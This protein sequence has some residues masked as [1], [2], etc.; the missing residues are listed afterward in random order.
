MAAR[1]PLPK[2][3]KLPETVLFHRDHP[4]DPII[5]LQIPNEDASD[6][7]TYILRTDRA[8]DMEWMDKLVRAGDLR[9]KLTMEMHVAHDVKSGF[10]T[11]IDD[12]DAPSF[13]ARNLQTA[14]AQASTSFA[15]KIQQRVQRRN[16]PT[17]MLRRQL[18]GKR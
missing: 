2:H 14:R 7:E 9:D 11:A 18:G 5:V 10:L 1:L 8:D 12:I 6:S 3:E 15:Q 17:S 4:S 13:M 16:V